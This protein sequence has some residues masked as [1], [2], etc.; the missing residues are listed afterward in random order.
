[1]LEMKAAVEHARA[2]GAQ[3][4]P[5][6]LRQ[7]FVARYEAL[8]ASGLAANPPP[9]RGPRRRGRIKQTPAR[10][11]LERLW[12]GQE[13]VLAFLDDLTIPFD[14]NQ[15]ER[16]LRML[17]VQQKV[18]GSFRSE[19]GAAA[20]ARIRGYLSTLGKQGQALLAALE[21]LFAGHPLYPALGRTDR[22]PCIIQSVSQ[23]TATPSRA[24]RSRTR[25][26]G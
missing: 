10:N 13:A 23:L 5:T 22:L 9:A 12:L 1:L 11:L 20:F 26:A 25:W 3:Q 18:S 8:L 21:A 17:K 19:T 15:A 7:T 16:D 2:Q 24:S 6:A 14:N 4:L